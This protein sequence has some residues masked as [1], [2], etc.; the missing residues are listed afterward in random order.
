MRCH[1]SG[2]YVFPGIFSA[3]AENGMTDAMPSL[4]RR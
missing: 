3:E 1:S 2:F 4:Q